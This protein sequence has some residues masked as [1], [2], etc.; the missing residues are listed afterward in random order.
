MT[1]MLTGLST[2]LSE[3]YRIERELGAGGMATVLLA[4]DLKH[5]RRV[6][7]KVLRPELAGVLG[8]ERFLAEIRTTAALQHPNI[9]PLFDSGAVDGF[10][11]YVMPYIEGE[12][13]R[14]RINREGQLS[15]ERAVRIAVDVAEALDYAHRQGVIHRDI[16]PENILLRDGRALVADF[17]IA[18]AVSAAGGDRLTETGLSIGT[19][20]YMSP[21]QATAAPELTGRTDVYS[22]ATVLYEMLAGKPP[23]GG[24][25]AQAIIARILTKDA[26]PLWQVRKSV[27]PNVSA[28]VAKALERVPADRFETAAEFAGALADQRFT[29]SVGAA[30]PAGSRYLTVGLAIATLL[31]T[32][33]VMW[34]WTRGTPGDS[35]PAPSRLAVVVP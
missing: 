25:S 11:Y 18:L 29:A 30:R 16:K 2:A 20:Q 6:A 12:T 1:G 10:L 7:V 8:P 35:G 27:P 24:T 21:E 14:G 26:E 9:L 22:L 34:G 4:D 13:L 17:G 31:L 3:R 5:H 23:H 32:S 15:I 28:A 19:P 33:V